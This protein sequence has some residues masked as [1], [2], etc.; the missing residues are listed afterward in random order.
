[1]T[2]RLIREGNVYMRAALATVIFLLLSITAFAQSPGTSYTIRTEDILR[3][4]VYGEQQVNVEVPVGE[5][6]YISAPFVGSVKA[7]GKT[8][9][10]L[11]TELVDL[12]R[13]KLRL[14]DPKVAVTFSRFAPKR[15]SITGA[16]NRAGQYE[17]RPGDRVVQLVALGGD[18][19]E[20]A[21]DL[22]RARLHRKGTE[23]WIP[24]DL[25]SVLHRGDLSQDYELQ[26]GDEL[27]IPSDTRNNVKVDG[28]VQRPG[29]YAYREPMTVADALSQAGWEIPNKSRMSRVMIFREIPADPGSYKM[30]RCDIVRYVHGDPSQNI[31]LQPNDFVYVP[32]T[33]TP[34][35]NTIGNV[36]NAAF[37]IDNIL[38]NGLFGLRIFR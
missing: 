11:E 3:I 4:Q 7:A 22:H 38:R 36:V 33:N 18:V 14:R 31:E 28:F 26:D 25:F 27:V 37:F 9:S 2:A 6:G 1:M 24:V 21:A 20:G 19:V 30:I 35:I 12:Y 13:L 16:V 10:Q 17:F 15:A 8:T 32:A 29:Q 5:D 23:E 34:D